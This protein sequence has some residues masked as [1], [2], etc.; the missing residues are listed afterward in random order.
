M[1]HRWV[2]IALTL[3]AA[4]NAQYTTASLGEIV[5]DTS[6]A[7]V[8]GTKVS[9]KNTETGFALATDAGDDGSFLFPRLPIGSYELTA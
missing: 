6:G 5:A 8:A 4:A 1:P 2:I 3:S 9:V 7:R